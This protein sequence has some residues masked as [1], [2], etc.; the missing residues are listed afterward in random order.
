MIKNDLVDY[1]RKEMGRGTSKETLLSSLKVGGWSEQDIKDSFAEAEKTKTNTYS[2]NST[3]IIDHP[4]HPI[5]WTIAKIV[6]ILVITFL[7]VAYILGG[8]P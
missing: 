1:L 6:I 3:F 4:H 8:Q 5:G 2:S 7:V